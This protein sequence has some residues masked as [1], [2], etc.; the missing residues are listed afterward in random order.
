MNK[1][2]PKN[3]SLDLPIHHDTYLI[4]GKIDNWKGE[5]TNVISTLMSKKENDEDL[6]L[7]DYPKMDKEHALLALDAGDKAYSNGTGEWP[8]M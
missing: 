5:F 1:T 2:V 7:G 6:V 8:T 4:N 3:F